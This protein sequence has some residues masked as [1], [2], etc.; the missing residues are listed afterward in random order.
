MLPGDI[1]THSFRPFPNSP[2]NAVGEVRAEVIEARSRGVLFDI[3]HGMGSFSFK[4]ARAM[5]ANG[6]LPDCISSD[7]H[8]LCID[9]PAF[10]LLTTMSK[11][12]CLGMPLQE[13][14][15]SATEAPA[16]ALRRG[17]L[18]SFNK[19]GVG[20]ASVFAIETGSF[21]YV[22]STGERMTGSRRLVPRGIVL[23]GRWWSG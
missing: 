10:D 5:L 7:V 1:L 2:C 8:A 6:F 9:G 15:R 20:D 21:E 23:N 16:R 17:D 19:E 11:F 4:T 3:G 22:D 14:V 12:I 18:G 13:V